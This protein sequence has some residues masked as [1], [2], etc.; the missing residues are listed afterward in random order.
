MA[1][2]RGELDTAAFQA[3][4]AVEVA[5]RAA[6]RL[7]DDLVGVKLMRAAFRPDD[8]PLVDGE[9]EAGEKQ[10]RMDLFA[11]AVGSFK[12]P[13]SHRDVELKDPSEAIEI[14]MLA[15]HLLRIIDHRKASAKKG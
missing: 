14:V 13:H 5:V 8:G 6:A 12:N 3:M 10:A 2:N 7:P 9:M 15:N 4:K 11:G 1:F